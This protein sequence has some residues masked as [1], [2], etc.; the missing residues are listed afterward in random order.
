M[1]IE[2]ILFGVIALVLVFDFA[3]KGIKKKTTQDDVAR[4]EEKFDRRADTPG[5]YYTGSWEKKFYYYKKTEREASFN[6]HI[7]NIFKLKLWLF[8]VSF[9][10]LGVLVLIFNDKI[11]AR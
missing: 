7:Q 2:I 10:S 1:S 8:A 6:F 5:W 11:K 3:L 4:D 9:A